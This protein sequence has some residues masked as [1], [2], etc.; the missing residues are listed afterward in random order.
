[1]IYECLEL[2]I[3]PGVDHASYTLIPAWSTQ[4]VLDL[5]GLWE[6]E[7][8]QD[9]FDP[10]IEMLIS[11]SMEEKCRLKAKEL[12]QVYQKASEESESQ[13]PAV[14]SEAE[15]VDE[16][17]KEYGGQAT[18]RCAVSQA[19]FSSNSRAQASLMQGK[20]PLIQGF[21]SVVTYANCLRAYPV[22]TDVRCA[23]RPITGNL[24]GED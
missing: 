13:A 20:K 16:E 7:V 21:G 12:Q 14:N 5:L 10:A 22:Y 15:E 1:M 24:F 19:A 6:E 18:E 2:A 11:T 8:V 17:E 23:N 4:E 9:S 3:I